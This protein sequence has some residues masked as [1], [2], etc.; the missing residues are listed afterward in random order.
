MD[1]LKDVKISS[2]YFLHSYAT[3][4]IRVNNVSS[5]IFCFVSLSLIVISSYQDRGLNLVYC[6]ILIYNT[7]LK[8]LFYILIMYGII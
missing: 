1:S 4:L 8:Y 6:P 5:P 2:W 3:V 7:T